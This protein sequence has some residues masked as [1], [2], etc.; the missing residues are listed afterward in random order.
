MRNRREF[1]PV[2]LGQNIAADPGKERPGVE[3]RFTLNS[4]KMG[5]LD[6]ALRKR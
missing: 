4:D 6:G 5:A 2:E 3:E 1:K